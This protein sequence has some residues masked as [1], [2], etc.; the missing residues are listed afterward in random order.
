MSL[1]GGQQGRTVGR[2]RLGDRPTSRCS[3][4]GRRRD[5][6]YNRET[7]LAA[8]TPLN[9]KALGRQVQQE[10]DCPRRA[11][12]RSSTSFQKPPM[13]STRYGQSLV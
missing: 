8:P 2:D 4:C 1:S 13:R 12:P 10:R 3:G 7:G 11:G 9:G 5:I 6:V